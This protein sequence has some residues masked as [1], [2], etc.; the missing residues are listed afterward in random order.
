[1]SHG[2]Q[3]TT[4]QTPSPD[5]QPKVPDV[6]HIVSAIPYMSALDT[7]GLWRNALRTL[8]DATKAV[9]HAGARVVLCAVQ[10]E[11]ER[12]EARLGLNEDGFPWPSTRADGGSGNLVAENWMREG[13]LKFMGYSVG[14]TNGREDSVRERMLTA[15]FDGPIPPAF[16]RDYMEKWSRPGTPARLRQLA[17]TLAAFARNAKRRREANMDSAISDWEADLEGTVAAS[18]EIGLRRSPAI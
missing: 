6:G 13:L 17:E 10:D 1:M 15:I 5:L 3:F 16:P 11:W 12:R 4:R 18:V 7:V 9:R 8:E 2:D 14:E